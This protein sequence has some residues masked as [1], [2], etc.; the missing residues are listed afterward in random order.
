VVFMGLLVCLPG[1]NQ[2]VLAVDLQSE[3]A[4]RDLLTTEERAWL[5]AHPTIRLGFDPHHEPLMTKEEDGSLAGILPEIYAELEKIPL[6]EPLDRSLP[7]LYHGSG[8]Q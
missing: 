2:N 5:K 7:A 8:R 6:N 1:Q 4:P 3:D